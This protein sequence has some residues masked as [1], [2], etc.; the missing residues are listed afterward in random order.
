MEKNLVHNSVTCLECGETLVS[1]HTHDYKTCSCENETMV[2][3]GLSYGRYG[4]KDLDKVKTN[5]V[6]DDEPFEKIREV[7]CRGGRGIDGKQPLK[8]VLLKDIDDE[9][10]GAIIDYEEQYRPNNKYLPIYYKELNYRNNE[11]DLKTKNS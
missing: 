4:G 5:Y 1:F 7:V 9:W 11:K 6:Y 2:D 8:Y 10:L 3:G